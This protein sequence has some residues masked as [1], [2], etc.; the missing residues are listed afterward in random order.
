MKFIH[1]VQQIIQKFLLRRSYYKLYKTIYQNNPLLRKKAISEDKW[2]QKWKSLD[3]HIKI[4]SYRIFS[5]YIGTDLNILPLEYCATVIEPLLNPKQFWPYYNDK[6]MFDKIFGLDVLPKTIIRNIDGVYYTDDY[7]IYKELFLSIPITFKYV[8]IKPAIDGESGKGVVK[9]QLS[10]EK[11]PLDSLNRQFGKNFIIQECLKQH[12][13]MAQFNSTSVNTIRVMTYRSLITNE[14][15]IPNAILRV[16]AKGK[17]VDNAHAGGMFC[18]ISSD[19]VLGK[20][21]CDYLGNKKNNFNGV[22]YL[23]SDFCIPNY[24]NIKKYAII[25]AGRVLHH[26][27]L[28]LD[29]MLNEQGTPKLIEVNVGGFSAWLFQYTNGGAFGQYTDE[30]ISFLKQKKG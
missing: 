20:Y 13:Y 5:H 27:L 9:L 29:I 22:D 2:L 12:P 11:I 10:N 30:V 3:S 17:D 15:V 23:N 18:G 28:A 1:Q 21:M 4:D 8:I 16:G 24:D 25:V 26:R 14:I 7:K 19:G 6:N